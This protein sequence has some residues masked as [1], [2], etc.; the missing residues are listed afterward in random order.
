M[1]AYAAG[2]AAERFA[3]VQYLRREAA[4]GEPRISA[5]EASALR[6][7]ASIIDSG[8]HVEAACSSQPQTS[9]RG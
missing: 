8:R 2:V 1:D 5:A 7:A 4:L 3:V 9:K 6:T